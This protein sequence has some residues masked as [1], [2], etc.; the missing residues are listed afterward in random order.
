MKESTVCGTQKQA[1]FSLSDYK[2]L[3]KGIEMSL[4]NDQDNSLVAD[5]IYKIFQGCVDVP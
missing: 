5:A 4:K 1:S 2:I 3:R